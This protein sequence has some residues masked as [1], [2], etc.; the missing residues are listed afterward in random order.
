[1]PSFIHRKVCIICKSVIVCDY[2]PCHGG[3]RV[4]VCVR[5]G[6]WV[7]RANRWA[8]AGGRAREHQ[9]VVVSIGTRSGSSSGV[10]L[11][12]R[13]GYL[14]PLLNPVPQSTA[15]LLQ[16]LGFSFVDPFVLDVLRLGH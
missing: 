11:I 15:K 7:A 2:A 5:V 10:R 6:V 1:M 3:V 9:V 12:Q 8:R 16:A 13:D 14:V 4:F